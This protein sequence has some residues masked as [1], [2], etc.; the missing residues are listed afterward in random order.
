VTKVGLVTH[1]GQFLLSNTPLGQNLALCDIDTTSQYLC[2]ET[3]YATLLRRLSLIHYNKL[4]ILCCYRWHHAVL[5]HGVEYLNGG[6]RLN[7]AA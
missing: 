5:S 4:L 2:S 3:S 1:Q 6:L 7:G